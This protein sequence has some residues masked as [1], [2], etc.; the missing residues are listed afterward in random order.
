M[1]K[2]LS[3]ILISSMLLIVDLSGAG[4]DANLWG[5]S[6][7]EI[8]SQA[9]ESGRMKTFERDVS[10]RQI[11]EV[12]SLINGRVSDVLVGK[13]DR[14]RTGQ[15]LLRLDSALVE[16]N[17]KEA[18]DSIKNWEKILFKREHW[19]VRSERA[20]QQARDKIA[21][22]RKQLKDN[23]NE[24]F[25]RQIHALISGRVIDVVPENTE[26]SE[27]TVVAVIGD[28]SL[29]KI[30]LLPEDIPSFGL[31]SLK[32]GDRISLTFNEINFACS[33]EIR[34]KTDGLTI[35]IPNE[36]FLISPGMT[37]RFQIESEPEDRLLARSEKKE[38]SGKTKKSPRNKNKKLEWGISGGLS[39]V[40]PGEYRYRAEGIDALMEQVAGNYG[41]EYTFSGDFGKNIFT[42]PIQAQFNYRLSDR[43]YLKAGLEFGYGRYSPAKTYNLEWAMPTE[44]VQIDL[45]TKL[46]YLMPFAGAE[47]R[48]G[49]FGIYASL[50]YNFLHFSHQK[51]L[52]S[53]AGSFWLRQGDTISANGSGFGLLLGGKYFF[54]IGKKT[55]LF[56]NL[57]L[58]YLK[59]GHLKGTRESVQSSSTGETF[60]ES[61]SGTIYSF[62][63][64]PYDLGWFST[65]ELYASAPSGSDFRNAGEMLLNLSGIRLMIGIAF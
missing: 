47:T 64:N 44:T 41:I 49:R 6:G 7:S 19:K 63:T 46:M 62:E 9:G 1:K 30:E 32:S 37:A 18:E 24:L 38:P 42:V 48:F 29:L 39:Y 43:W 60:S 8:R 36:K 34:R 35:L 16:Q 50:G 57:E 20:E 55:D 2:I 17:M 33:G 11:L 13:G 45:S 61:I 23:K 65:W 21:S 27:E 54:N 52:E 14:V 5:I 31:D 59:I 15:L 40:D 56:V 53:S 12:R 58:C 25:Q 28:D 4:Q 3:V 26:V 10:C 22:Y 51:D